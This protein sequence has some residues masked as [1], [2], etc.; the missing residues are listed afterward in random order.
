MQPESAIARVVKKEVKKKVRKLR[1]YSDSDTDDNEFDDGLVR[2][3]KDHH[4]FARSETCPNERNS[5]R[6]W[7]RDNNHLDDSQ[8]YV[9]MIIFVC[10]Q[11]DN[12]RNPKM[13]KISRNRQ[14]KLILYFSLFTIFYFFN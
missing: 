3:R 7:L 9:G 6:A 13:F 14:T 4:S 1:G 10:N 5:G 12:E 2:S 8:L 11:D